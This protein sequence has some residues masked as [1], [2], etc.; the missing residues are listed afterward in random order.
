MSDELGFNAEEWLQKANDEKSKSTKNTKRAPETTYVP[1]PETTDEEVETV[2][3]RIEASQTDITLGYNNWLNIGFALSDEFGAAGRSYF[4]RVSCFHPKYD[5]KQTDKQYD[6]CMGS[7]G[8]GITIKSFF[9]QAKHAG[10][11]ITH[12]KKPRTLLPALRTKT[13]VLPKLV[14]ETRD[15]EGKQSADQSMPIEE[16]NSG[17][18]SAHSVERQSD[19]QPADPEVNK[20]NIGKPGEEVEYPEI[21]CPD[22]KQPI[23]GSQS[24]SPSPNDPD[25]TTPGT[26][27][28]V[29]EEEDTPGDGEDSRLNESFFNTPRLT[30]SVH[31]RIPT[32]LRE[33][34]DMFQE[35]IEKDVVLV[36]SLTVLSA[37][38]PNI[39]GIY[40]DEMY[41]PHLFTFIAAPA[42][43]GKGRAKWARYLGAAIHYKMVEQSKIEKSEY[44]RELEHYLNMPKAQREGVKHPVPPKRR[45][46]FIPAN[47][48][49]SGFIQALADNNYHGMIFETEADTLAT[50]LRQEWGNFC[51]VL[52]KAFHHEST[53]MFRR[54]ESEHTEVL[55]PHLAILLAGTPKQIHNIMPTVENGLF[56]RFLYYAFE[57]NS[58]FRNPF[59]SYK[60]VNYL[61][62]FTEK[63]KLVLDFYEALA[64]RNDKIRFKFTPSQGELF[65]QRF[66]ILYT[67][68]RLLMDND[69]NAS[70]RRLGL[71]TFRIAMV[72][73]ALRMLEDG[74]FPDELVCSD[75]DFDVASQIAFILEQHAIA[76]FRT[77]PD[78]QKRVKKISFYLSLPLG[79]THQ[80][81][82]NV[83]REMNINER[84]ARRYIRD[85]IEIGWLK[86]EYNWYSK[87]EFDT[88]KLWEK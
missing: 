88:K 12:T 28:I 50:A 29:S 67:R 48:S 70:S 35:D 30:D 13:P 69:F 6:S 19:K 79:F 47:S 86:H 61:E 52:R 42:G 2:I 63:G 65:T 85:L 80:D 21:Q 4:H 22:I 41:T 46:F 59:V 31:H 87:I 62:Y 40:F 83:A 78:N 8:G 84:T 32:L 44:E 43:S 16:N 33:C 51:D 54:K 77:L 71:I 37:C 14:W 23:I 25:G 68:N 38:L 81:Y 49:S 74:H 9:H 10:I 57:D 53:T 55:D 75:T 11:D 3:R 39:E 15:S 18:Q 76:V 64:N 1:S 24:A 36:S 72:L 45:M 7:Q 34:C 20:P 27:E 66:N 56:S 73:S 60:D 26:K 17:S 5:H 82:L 58:D